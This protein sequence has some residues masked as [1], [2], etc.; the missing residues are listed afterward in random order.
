[1]ILDYA[2]LETSEIN[3]IIDRSM[4]DLN[5]KAVHDNIHQRQ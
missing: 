4:S 2:N 1:M 3:Q 5:F